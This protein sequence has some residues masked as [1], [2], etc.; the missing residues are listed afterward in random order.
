M[1]DDRKKPLPRPYGPYIVT[2]MLTP[3]KVEDLRREAE[4][5]RAY[6]KAKRYPKS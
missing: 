4:E 6:S 1:A 2:E 5:T 3:E